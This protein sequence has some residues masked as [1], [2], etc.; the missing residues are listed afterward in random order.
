MI[1][2]C[3]PFYNE[4]DMLINHLQWY[5][6][7]VDCTV[8]C[9]SDHTFS[10]KPKPT[11]LTEYP[12]I[13][14]KYAKRDVLHVVYEADPDESLD[15]WVREFR[16]RDAMYKI[17]KHS[18]DVEPQDIMLINDVDEFV[19]HETLAMLVMGVGEPTTMVMDH[20]QG[21]FRCKLNKPWPGT[22]VSP[23]PSL[24]EN[25]PS[26]YRDQRDRLPLCYN[27]GWHFSY[28]GGVKSIQQKFEAY[29]HVELNTDYN[30]DAERI[31]KAIDEGTP[32]LEQDTKEV[33]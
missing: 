31:Q 1:Y 18:E 22:V 14:K 15:P 19:N 16:H 5:E 7:I 32:I 23:M 27:G 20:Y 33:E 9:E 2:D 29:S 21:S 6:D 12:E 30:K 10:G 28:F 4:F 13:I 3:F 24:E 11:W 8:I 26:K 25:P 17:I